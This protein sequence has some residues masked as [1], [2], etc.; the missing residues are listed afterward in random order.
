M[1]RQNR[2][3]RVTITGA[4][5]NILLLIFK[6][7]AGII[8][9]SSAMI[10]DAFHSLSDFASD[11]V[12]LIFVRISHKASDHDHDYGHGKFETLAS[13]GIGLLLLGAGAGIMI[14]GIIK[15]IDF[16]E[17]ARIGHPN[18][19]ALAA[20]IIS[21][22]FKEWLFRYTKKEA[23]ITESPALLANA[24][25]HRTD[26]LTSIAALIGIGGAMLP[27]RGWTIL[28]PLAALAVSGFIV[29]AS[30]LLIRP[31]IDELMEKS[32][33]E[34]E[35]EEIARI[36]LGTSGILG[37]HHLR[38]RRIGPARAIEVHIK[39]PPLITLIRAHDIATNIEKSLKGKFG[40]NTHIA[41]HME[42]ARTERSAQ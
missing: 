42:P 25:H 33:P 34:N 23:R 12:I 37:F 21:I 1:D 6:F 41:I 20:A 26:A 22:I 10:A 14:D 28:D 2:I 39:L 13:L 40:D 32:L 7:A 35:K 31:C 3:Y 17:G 4:I 5:V 11:V 8:G 16:Y 19:W 38:T 15:V 9:H 29:R 36:I 18:S 27:G 30:V 24:W